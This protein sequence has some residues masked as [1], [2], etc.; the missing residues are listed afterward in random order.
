MKTQTGL[1]E[2]ST[3]VPGGLIVAIALAPTATE[4][5]EEGRDWTRQ[6]LGL[7]R[8]VCVVLGLPEGSGP[9]F[10]N[11]LAEQGGLTVYFHAPEAAQVRAVRE[12]AERSGW[13]GMRVFAGEG[14]YA[15][16][17]L[18]D[19]LAG[20]ILVCDAAKSSVS[21][22]ELL[23]VLHPEGKALLSGKTLVKP[24]PP[25]I[26]DWSH[27]L[28]GPDNN[29]VS[30]DRV[31]RAPYLTQ[32][33]AKPLFGSWPPLTVAAGGRF[34]R[35]FGQ[36]GLRPYTTPYVNTLMAFNGY[37]G[38]LLWR[39]ALKEGFMAHRHT[40]VATPDVLYLG[41][42]ESCKKLDT[43]SGAVLGEI[44]PPVEQA[45]GTVWKWMALE[46]GVLYALLGGKEAEA[47]TYRKSGEAVPLGPNFYPMEEPA[48]KEPEKSWAFGRDLLAIDIETG[49]VLWR[50]RERDPIDGRATA[51]KNGRL[52]YYRKN[53]FLACLDAKSGQIIWRNTDPNT[54]SA[55]EHYPD[56]LPK[57]MRKDGPFWTDE[58]HRADSILPWAVP[59]IYMTAGDEGLYFASEALRNLTAMST[60]NGN[61]LWKTPQRPITEGSRRGYDNYALCILPG[62][63]YGF[64]YPESGK[65]RAPDGV[66]SPTTGEL[67][68]ALRSR[69]GC[70][71]PTAGVDGVFLRAAHGSARMDPETGAMSWLCSA[72]PGCTD[73]VIVANGH[74]YLG[75]WCCTCPAV[76]FGLVCLGP[77]GGFRFDAPAD[78]PRQLVRSGRFSPDVA[79]IEVSR[80]DWPAFQADNARSARSEVAVRDRL[81][82]KWTHRPAW[83]GQQRPATPGNPFYFAAR[84]LPTAATTAGGLVFFGASDG[85]V[86]ALDARTGQPRWKF[87]AGGEVFYPPTIAGGRAYV[88]ANDGWLYV[89]SARDGALLW[90]FRAH[91]VERAI[92]IHERLTSTWPVAGGV[93]VA[94]GVVYLASGIANHD[95]THVYALDAATGK[96]RWHN[97]ASGKFDRSG[98]GVSLAGCLRLRDDRLE[99]NGGPGGF[100]VARYDLR[101]GKYLQTQGD[102]RMR[103]H[104]PRELWHGQ[105]N[106]SKLDF[107]V[108]GGRKLNLLPDSVALFDS[109]VDVPAVRYQ[110]FSKRLSKLPAHWM[111][112]PLSL[113]RA[114]ATTPNRVLLAGD[115]AEQKGRDQKETK[116]WLV[117]LDLQDGS[118]V[119]R[120]E[121][122]APACAWG[123][124]LDHDGRVFVSLEDGR[125]LCFQ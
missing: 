117:T 54:L 111:A 56:C 116:S 21:E 89:L 112:K 103:I 118:E 19:N 38:V 53:K 52:Y 107:P 20:A 18:A 79:R 3:L 106:D 63:I 83:H 12:A 65:N 97:N 7:R 45:G 14:E 86:R 66:F 99:F 35:I 72:R 29:P 62:G 69:R 13:L 31:A 6:I 93:V 43:R 16:L 4:A 10:A 24:F 37:N 9:E 88:G 51:L 121:L 15:K 46:D 67:L 70:A 102:G 98:D 104:H 84:N 125:V 120:V 85:S 75:Q 61:L 22:A 90:K 60:K 32:F 26:E 87:Y 82:L 44:K 71:V 100:E 108:P 119:S 11:L 33:M 123:L 47:I 101:T 77:A 68:R 28:H 94:E 96:V 81:E 110:L 95:G 59:R 74:L 57:E 109:D 113:N 23:R 40:L 80:G 115:R 114:I 27:P 1:R 17:P 34:F 30:R 48:Y 8:G 25:G 55:I 124:A 78:E 41:D 122:P 58:A 92:M 2:A 36:Q 5:G 64:N 49:K 50:H 76:L 42:D 91:P 73:G 105:R 39:R